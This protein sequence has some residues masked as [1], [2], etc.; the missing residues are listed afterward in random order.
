MTLFLSIGQDL[1]GRKKLFVYS[2][3]LLLVGWICIVF[4]ESF[5]VNVLGLMLLWGFQ[6]VTCL[7]LYNLSNELLV[8]PLRNQSINMYSILICV[9]GIFGNYLTNY[10][11]SFRSLSTVIFL[12]YTFFFFL[13]AL[14]LPE[15]PNILLKKNRHQELK[16]VVKQ[17]SKTNGLT[18]EELLQAL[19]D[20][21]SV[22]ECKCDYSNNN[23]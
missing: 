3:L 5:V 18:D 13:V 22:I 20:V 1:L 15:S 8:N 23:F 12:V 6:E 19:N 17:I 10:L 7:A 14:C 11:T 9:G 21:E 2:Y 4:F 16:E